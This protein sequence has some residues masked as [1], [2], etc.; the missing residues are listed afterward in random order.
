MPYQR[1]ALLGF[2]SGCEMDFAQERGSALG[3][4]D[5]KLGRRNKSS[6]SAGLNAFRE[7]LQKGKNF[8]CSVGI[9][10]TETCP[11]HLELRQLEPTG[12]LPPMG[13]C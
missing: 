7:S 3:A 6:G 5:I 9:H 13:I 4:L 10:A 12:G 8:R 1:L 11:Q 2:Q